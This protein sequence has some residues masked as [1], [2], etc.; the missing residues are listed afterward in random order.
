M[1]ISSLWPGFVSKGYRA[2]PALGTARDWKGPVPGF[3]GAL[4]PCALQAG[5]HNRSYNQTM[6]TQC[7]LPSDLQENYMST[8]RTLMML[9][10][11]VKSYQIHSTE[12]L[13]LLNRMFCYRLNVCTPSTCIC[14]STIPLKVYLKT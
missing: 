7:V 5:L 1:Q 11:P 6:S 4:K 3:T 12:T 8:Q 13:A 2:A 14:Q 10:I 9:R